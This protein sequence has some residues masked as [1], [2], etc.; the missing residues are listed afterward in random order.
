MVV[1]ENLQ[2]HVTHARLPEGYMFDEG[3]KEE[4]FG[5]W[6]IVS[7]AILENHDPAGSGAMVVVG[8]RREGQKKIRDY[9]RALGPFQRQPR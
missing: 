2:G 6:M 1:V 3:G 5:G 4:G 9:R 7:E 8:K